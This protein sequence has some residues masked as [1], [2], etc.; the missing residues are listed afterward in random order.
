MVHLEEITGDRVGTPSAGGKKR[1]SKRKCGRSPGGDRAWRPRAGATLLT[2]LRLA[3]AIP[4]TE[5]GAEPQPPDTSPPLWGSGLPAAPTPCIYSGA[6]R[7]HGSE[8]RYGAAPAGPRA[9]VRRAAARGARSRR[10]AVPGATKENHRGA[11]SLCAQ[12]RDGGQ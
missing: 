12:G 11:V 2:S 10:S 5:L 6:Q 8:G 1:G 4:G 9:P 7:N 3:R